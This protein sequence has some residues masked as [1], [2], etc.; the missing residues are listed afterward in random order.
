MDINLDSPVFKAWLWFMVFAAALAALGVGRPRRPLSAWLGDF[1]PRWGLAGILVWVVVHGIWAARELL[2]M[3]LIIPFTPI[4]AYLEY[5]TYWGAVLT[6]VLTIT[7]MAASLLLSA[8]FERPQYYVRARVYYMAA[9]PEYVAYR[10]VEY[11][12]AREEEPREYAI[13]RSR[14]RGAVAH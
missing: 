5:G 4:E 7:F 9:E 12:R 2:N 14:K 8:I 1:F 13:A 11:G 3:R 10:E 6:G